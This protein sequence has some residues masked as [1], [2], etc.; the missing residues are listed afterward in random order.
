M[1]ADYFTKPLQEIIFNVSREIIMGWKHV[2]ELELFL[3]HPSKESV[4]KM[5][6]AES[7]NFQLKKKSYVDVLLQK[8]RVK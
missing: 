6:E 3:P 5:D 8:L 7:A 1:L 4:G 2:I